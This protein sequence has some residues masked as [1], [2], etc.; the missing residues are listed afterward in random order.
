[1]R[2][3]AGLPCVLEI[4]ILISIPVFVLGAHY[5]HLWPIRFVDKFVCLTILGILT[6]FSQALREDNIFVATDA[7]LFFYLG[8][9]LPASVFLIM[10]LPRFLLTFLLKLPTAINVAISGIFLPFG[11]M[12][13][14]YFGISENGRDELSLEI[15]VLIAHYW[16]AIADNVILYVDPFCKNIWPSRKQLFAFCEHK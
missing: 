12:L 11:A 1:M 13:P 5:Y 7:R 16:I 6:R 4:C 3:D 14:I 9:A 2:Y 10:M 15:S 8:I